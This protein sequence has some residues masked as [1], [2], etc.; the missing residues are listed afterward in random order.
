MET[1]VCGYTMGLACADFLEAE[2]GSPTVGKAA[3]FV[4][5]SR[6]IL[7]AVPEGVPGAVAETVVGGVVEHIV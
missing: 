1:A 5:R 2:R 6:G 7:R 3:D 4:V